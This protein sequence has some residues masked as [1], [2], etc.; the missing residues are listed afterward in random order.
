[1]RERKGG[2]PSALRQST[3]C[4]MGEKTWNKNRGYVLYLVFQLSV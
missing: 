1:M 4:K 2:E 3:G